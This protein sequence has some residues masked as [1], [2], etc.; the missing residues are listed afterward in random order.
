MKDQWNQSL[1]E[2]LEMKTTF[3]SILIKAR[4]TFHKDFIMNSTA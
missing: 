1:I 4:K 2:I 3:L